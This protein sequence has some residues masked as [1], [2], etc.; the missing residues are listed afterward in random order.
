MS[1]GLSQ[2][3]LLAFK[4]PCEG[5]FCKELYKDESGEIRTCDCLITEHRSE[6]QQASS[7]GIS[8]PQAGM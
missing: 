4:S 6:Q 3:K 1:C 2:E 5:R 7:Q 8:P